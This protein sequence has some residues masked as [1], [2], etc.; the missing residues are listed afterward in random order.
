MQNKDIAI[1]LS[2]TIFSFNSS[3]L[4]AA[5]NTDTSLLPPIWPLLALIIVLVV[6]RKQLNCVP[7]PEFD[8]TPTALTEVPPKKPDNIIDLKDGLNQ[9]QAS[10]AKGTRCKRKTTLTDAR[11]SIA[12]NTYQLTVCKQHNTD[13]LKPFSELIK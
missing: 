8:D 5:E 7:K 13:D 3:V 6:F 1:T 10:T 9:C 12:D 11:I 2:A 4:M